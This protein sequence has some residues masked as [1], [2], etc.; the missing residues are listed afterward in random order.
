MD[1]QIENISPNN[2]EDCTK[3]TICTVYC[4]VSAVNPDYPGP[5]KAGPDGERYRLKNASFYDKALKFCLNCKRCEVSCPSNVRIGDIIQMARL[6]YD[7]RP[8]SLRDKM[9]ANTDFM[10]TLATKF[11]PIVNTTLKMPVTKRL[12]HMTMGIDRHRIMPRYT[13]ETFD[14]W[15]KK[16]A[17]SQDVFKNFVAYFHGCFVNYNNPKLGKDFVHIMNAIGYGVKPLGK[18]RCCGVAKIANKLIS[19]ARRDAKTNIRSME[20]AMAKGWNVLA[21]SSTCVF[22]MREEYP[23][24][25]G[26]DNTAVRNNISLA[27]TFINKLVSDAKVKLVFRDDF[28][29]RICYH[30]PCHMQKLGWKIHSV[31]LLNMIPRVTLVPLE[32]MCCGMAGTYGFKKENYEFSQAIGQDLFDNIYRAGADIVATDCETCKWQIEANTGM[33][34]ENPITIVAEALDWEATRKANGLT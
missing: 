27:T 21:T 25:L 24:L 10:G 20:T 6:K 28:K 19:E 17:P 15:M 30:T 33:R 11:S 7:T 3:C 9:L 29:A 32:S 18:E 14:D 5:K 34:V 23:H 1:Y 22:T 2:L 26:I 12:L 31:S 13:S 16:I 8:V 4:P